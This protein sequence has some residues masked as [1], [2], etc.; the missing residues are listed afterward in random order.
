MLHI[1]PMSPMTICI[2]YILLWNVLTDRVR[3]TISQAINSV[4]ERYSNKAT[5]QTAIVVDVT[6]SGTHLIILPGG[7]Q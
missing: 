5:L 6:H 2:V 3:F 1:Q 4:L 7:E